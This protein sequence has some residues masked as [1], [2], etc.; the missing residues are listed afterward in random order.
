MSEY[1]Q[2]K[3]K[4]EIII[5]YVDI[6]DE[7]NEVCKDKR[8]IYP[9]ESKDAYALRT[10]PLELNHLVWTRVADWMLN[11]A[12]FKVLKIEIKEVYHE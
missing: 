12:L 5:S 3:Y 8:V 4:I 1:Y 2:D 7:Q 6:E 11:H 10:N 9:L